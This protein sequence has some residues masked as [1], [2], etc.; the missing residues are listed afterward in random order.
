VSR[1]AIGQHQPARGLDSERLGGEGPRALL[2][3][4]AQRAHDLTSSL[5]VLLAELGGDLHEG[6]VREHALPMEL[7]YPG[8]A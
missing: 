5:D 2:A 7:A 1:A 4:D 6:R 8:L 3:D